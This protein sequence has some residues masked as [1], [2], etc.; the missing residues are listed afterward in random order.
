MPCSNVRVVIF[1]GCGRIFQQADFDWELRQSVRA[2]EDCRLKSCCATHMQHL[3][4]FTIWTVKVL[5]V[6]RRLGVATPRA[7]SC[8]AVCGLEGGCQG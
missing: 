8:D 2:P 7:M 4:V 3:G 6:V 1:A 5:C